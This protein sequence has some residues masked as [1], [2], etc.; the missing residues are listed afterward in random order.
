[1]DK[2]SSMTEQQWQQIC[3]FIDSKTRMTPQ[4]F[5]YKWDVNYEFIAKLCNCDKRTVF[6]WS[7][8]NF[9][10]SSSPTC[11]QF[12]L[13]TADLIIEKY[14]EMPVFLQQRFCPDLTR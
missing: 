5:M 11:Q 12:R 1:M 3:S 13:F 14:E 2:P 8:G 10:K 9:G 7:N 6:R 4:Q